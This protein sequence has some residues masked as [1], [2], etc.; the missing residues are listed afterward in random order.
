MPKSAVELRHDNLKSKR[1]I[2]L[3]ATFVAPLTILGILLDLKVVPIWFCFYIAVA[4]GA[5]IYM[6]Q[7]EYESQLE[8][9]EN[10]LEQNVEQESE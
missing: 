6:K 2:Y 5:I 10:M 9:I 4:V 7:E 8:E 1:D 3:G